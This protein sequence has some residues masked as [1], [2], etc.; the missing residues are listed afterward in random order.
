MFLNPEGGLRKYNVILFKFDPIPRSVPSDLK[1]W[2]TN[3]FPIFKEAF[4]ETKDFL[5]LPTFGIVS[6]LFLQRYACD[7]FWCDEVDGEIFFFRVD[8]FLRKKADEELFR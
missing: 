5:L 8:T 1:T 4:L 6:E 7:V 3:R 2:D